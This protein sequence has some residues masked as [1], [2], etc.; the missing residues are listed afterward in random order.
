[1]RR[2]ELGTARELAED[3]LAV[4]RMRGYRYIAGLAY[5]LI[6]ECVAETSPLIALE[7]VD[8]ALKILGSIGARND[9]A[10]TLVTRAMLCQNSGDFAAARGM[11]QKAKAIFE[12][13]GTLDEPVRVNAALAALDRMEL[14]PISADLSSVRSSL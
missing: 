1:L 13:L 7:H 12:R 14:K 4:S 10:K 6:A 11:L 3:V 8:E 5:R 9:L 2:G